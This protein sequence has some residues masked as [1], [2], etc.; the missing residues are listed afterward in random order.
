[1]LQ[2]FSFRKQKQV[3]AIPHEFY[4]FAQTIEDIFVERYAIDTKFAGSLVN[5]IEQNLDRILMVAFQH[6]QNAT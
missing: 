3:N 6:E 5:N 1:M 2:Q 4:N